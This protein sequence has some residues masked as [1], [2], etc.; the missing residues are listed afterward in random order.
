LG[1]QMKIFIICSKKFYSL[2]PSI[3]KELENLGHK[4]TFPNTYPDTNIEDK[5]RVV[6]EK[7]RAM[8]KSTMFKKS[9]ESVDKNDAILVLNF[10]KGD[11]KNY[12][13]GATFLEM[14]DAFRLNKKI[15]LYNPIPEG[16]LKDEIDGFCPIIIE[17]DLNRIK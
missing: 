15:F 8:W 17:G 5:F 3:Q 1:P 2:I 7:E 4:L 12:I 13:G 6:S 11:Y 14:Y 10:D 16:I 9:L